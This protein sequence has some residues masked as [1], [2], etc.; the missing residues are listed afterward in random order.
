ME[1]HNPYALRISG[2]QDR[3]H[4]VGIWDGMGENGWQ[5]I[6][7]SSA[8][9]QTDHAKTVIASSADVHVDMDKCTGIR[10]MMEEFSDPH[11][12]WHLDLDTE[13]T[14]EDTEVT[15]SQENI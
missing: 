13:D 11:S 15:T 2:P 8:K 6:R 3:P 1:I 14:T 10:F 12:T 7:F 5:F 9:K 4:W